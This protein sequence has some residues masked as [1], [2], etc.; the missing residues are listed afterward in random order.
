[1]KSDQRGFS[2]L[3][4]LT[5]MVISVIAIIGLAHSFAVGRALID[6]YATARAALTYAQGRAERLSSLAEH[7]PSNADLDLGVHGFDIALQGRQA[8]LSWRIDGVNDPVDGTNDPYDYKRAT[9]VVTWKYG[10]VTDSVTLS[11]TLVSP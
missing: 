5:A 6:R 7:D 9:M 3:E 10:G 1:M 2:L 11:R 8:T 4:V